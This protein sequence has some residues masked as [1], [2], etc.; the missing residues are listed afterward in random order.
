MCVCAFEQVVCPL[1][2]CP[3]RALCLVSGISRSWHNEGLR[4]YAALRSVE[5]MNS[6]VCMPGI[7]IKYSKA[8]KTCGTA[9]LRP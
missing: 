4:H 6:Q 9:Q 5:R 2:P 1:G 8:L 7:G 3:D